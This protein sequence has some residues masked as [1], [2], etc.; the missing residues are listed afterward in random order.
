VNNETAPKCVVCST[1]KYPDFGFGKNLCEIHNVC[2]TCGIKRAQ[3]K[4][5]PWAI[6]TGAF[7]CQP[8]EK[9]ERKVR[10]KARK[11]EGFDYEYTD[12]VVCPHCG[13]EYG[14]SWEMRDG[15]HECPE[16]EKS[17]DLVRE[18]SVS[19]TTSKIEDKPHD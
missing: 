6:R 13:Y 10:I 15:E 16:C 2:V 12:E 19:Y 5:T 7:Q 11:A 18:V 14:D 4:E 8:C 17:F 9:A 1:G 3:L